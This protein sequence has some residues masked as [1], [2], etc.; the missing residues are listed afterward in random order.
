MLRF[1]AIASIAILAAGAATSGAF[2]QRG[3]DAPDG[4]PQVGNVVGG[5]GATI[6][7]GGDDMVITRTR[8]GAGGGASYEQPGRVATFIGNDGGKPLFGYGPAPNTNPGR[9]ARLVGGGEDA[10]VLYAPTR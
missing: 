2:A 9:E 7:G 10:R 5:G 8:A 1:A 4:P 3:G 6:S